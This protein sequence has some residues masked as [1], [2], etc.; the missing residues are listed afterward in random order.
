MWDQCI[1]RHHTH[2][3][4]GVL[5]SAVHLIRRWGETG[6]PR[7]V[8]RAQ[9]EE[10]GYRG[11][12]THS[13]LVRHMDLE[14][15]VQTWE[16]KRQKPDMPEHFSRTISHKISKCVKDPPSPSGRNQVVMKQS[17]SVT[18]GLC[19]GFLANNAA[20]LSNYEVNY[21]L[22]HWVGG[23]PSLQMLFE[24]PWKLI[25]YPGVPALT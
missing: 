16:S 25:T 6:K 7:T 12:E 1:A 23:H 20:F 4:V 21:G 8:T 3:H 11:W 15:P 24:L 18:L 13:V 19:C 9:D 22:N 10:F 5:V 14:A 17:W 2:S